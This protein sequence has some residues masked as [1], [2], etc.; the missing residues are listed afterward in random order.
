VIA[1]KTFHEWTSCEFYGH[2]FEDDEDRPG[3]RRCTDC[4][5]DSEPDP[6]ATPSPHHNPR[7]ATTGQNGDTVTTA[8]E[9]AEFSPH[10]RGDCPKCG[11][12]FDLTKAGK[13][14][15]HKLPRPAGHWSGYAMA[16]CPGAGQA[17]ASPSPA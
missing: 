9:I 15:H 4:D 12:R 5:E 14:R 6:P 7:P 8:A 17:P 1:D 11:R 2:A 16:T 10:G 13:V 3:W